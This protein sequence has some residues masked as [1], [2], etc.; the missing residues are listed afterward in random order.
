MIPPL[1]SQLFEDQ[2]LL[3]TAC[4]VAGGNKAR[5][6]ALALNWLAHL[7][8]SEPTPEFR[9]GSILPDFASIATLQTLPEAFQ[10]GIR[11]H[12]QIDAYT[13]SHPIF[14][15]SVRRLDESHRRFGG[16][17]IDIFYDHILA[18]D[19]DAFNGTPLSEF[20]E[21]FY[22][23]FDPYWEWIPADARPRFQLMRRHNLLG[24]YSEL[25]G[26]S[27]ALARIGA[28][29]RRPVDLAS[30]VAALD[31]NYHSF[32]TDFHEFFPQICRHM[33]G[34]CLVDSPRP[35]GDKLHQ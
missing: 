12:R 13:D 7:H 4:F 16:V 15:R 18:R 23:S 11:H 6:L 14:R 34:V 22:A 31:H 21:E 27:E 32:H 10:R 24:S 9:L 28:R 29:L 2:I 8:L 5:Q 35:Q 26:I 30:S 33:D 20:V 25:S 3:S 1:P 19:W 17:I